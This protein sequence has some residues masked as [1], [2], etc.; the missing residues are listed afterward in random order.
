M[1]MWDVFGADR[2]TGKPL[3]QLVEA[4]TEEH[5]MRLVG[6]SMLIEKVQRVEEAEPPLVGGRPP[7]AAHEYHRPPA[8]MWGQVSNYP[9][10]T[11]GASLLKF[12][13]SIAMLFGSLGLL[14]G[15]AALFSTTDREYSAS[16]ILG[17]LGGILYGVLVRFVGDLGE[18]V[19]D[20]A[21]ASTYIANH[22]K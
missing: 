5:A 2:D 4:D 13:G 14:T 17:G 3:K 12:F 1:P 7:P 6:R 15:V 10:I 19:R 18:A 20:I 21:R 22:Q 8:A 11:S 16:L 9:A